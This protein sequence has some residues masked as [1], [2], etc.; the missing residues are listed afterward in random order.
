M[1]IRSRTSQIIPAVFLAVLA[2]VLPVSSATPPQQAEV[3]P[4]GRVRVH[5]G[6]HVNKRGWIEVDS[7]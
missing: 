2:S 7:R 3:H 1:N 5:V 6:G 4:K